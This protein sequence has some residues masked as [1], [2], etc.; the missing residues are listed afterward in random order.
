MNIK[1]VRTLHTNLYLL[2]GYFG[3]K[4]CVS[5]SNTFFFFKL[6]RGTE[7]DACL[8]PIPLRIGKQGYVCRDCSI[9]VHKPC[10]I[11]V[12]DHCMETSLP[13]MDL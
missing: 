3:C 9:T 12:T 1:A 6:S 2:K 5:I 7:C 8:T 13:N 4:H 10:H 11:K